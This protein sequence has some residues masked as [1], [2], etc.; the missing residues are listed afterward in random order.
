MHCSE[1]TPLALSLTGFTCTSIREEKL[2]NPR[3][4]KP[5]NDFVNTMD[6]L[7]LSFPK[8]LDVSVP[9]NMYCGPPEA[10]NAQILADITANKA[11]ILPQ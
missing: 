11:P 3:L 6:N 5:H 4:T 9:W 1:F 8:K 10:D 2:Y 7:G